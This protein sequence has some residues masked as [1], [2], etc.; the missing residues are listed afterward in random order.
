MNKDIVTFNKC[1]E[2]N[3]NG[4]KSMFSDGSDTLRCFY[5]ALNFNYIINTRTKNI[6]PIIEWN[7]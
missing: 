1:L 4:R 6:F 5:M 7:N 2:M 3:L